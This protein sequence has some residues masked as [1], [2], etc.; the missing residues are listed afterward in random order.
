[1]NQFF[2][3]VTVQN[4][5]TCFLVTCMVLGLAITGAYAE[6]QVSGY[7]TENTTW[8]LSG[9]PYVVTDDLIVAKEV[10]L[11]IDA[12]VVVK[13]RNKK[14][15]FIKGTLEADGTPSQRIHFTSW[16]DDIGGDTNGDDSIPQA[17]NWHNLFFYSESVN[18]V[19]DNVEIRYGGTDDTYDSAMLKSYSPSLT[20]T[21][22][23]IEKSEYRGIDIRNASPSVSITGCEIR[24]N[25]DYGIYLEDSDA[26][27][28]NNTIS[29]SLGVYLRSS[30]ATITGNT[31]SNNKYGFFVFSSSPRGF[32]I[33]FVRQ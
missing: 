17:G 5:L 11:K 24:E 25:D 23:I 10:K 18:N 12:G 30:N 29:D 7:I 32:N 33:K 1:M 27:I 19:L 16:R 3:K 13:F 8:T 28:K 14:S 4:I 31:V 22:S 9:S 21:D 15:I 6:T 26:Q 2:V 20:I